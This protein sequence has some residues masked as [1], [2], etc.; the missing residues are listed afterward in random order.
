MSWP[1]SSIRPPCS[2]VWP[3]TVASSVDL[4]TP[5]RPMID[6]VSPTASFSRISSSTTVSPYPARTS[7]SWSASSGMSVLLP[8]I[9]LSHL[10]IVADLL[11]RALREHRAGDEH[12]DLLREAEDDVH[13]VLDDQHGDVRIEGGHDVKDQMA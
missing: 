2:V 1:C 8:E 5:L 4:P 6:T 12:R 13:V 3:M 9:D 7:S 10:C 11:G